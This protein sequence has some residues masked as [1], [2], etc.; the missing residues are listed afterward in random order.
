M[1]CDSPLLVRQTLEASVTR[2]RTSAVLYNGW[3]QIVRR[4]LGSLCSSS[5]P[6][7]STLVT[8]ISLCHPRVNTSPGDAGFRLVQAFMHASTRVKKIKQRIT[9]IGNPPLPCAGLKVASTFSS[10]YPLG[11]KANYALFHSRAVPEIC[12]T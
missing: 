2:C 5:S 8:P 4:M 11:K 9:V 6:S 3:A 1:R 7:L 12:L 10:H